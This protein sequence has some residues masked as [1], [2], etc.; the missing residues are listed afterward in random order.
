MHPGASTLSMEPLIGR[1]QDVRNV[2]TLLEEPT[3]QL[4][5]LTGPGGVGKTR[6]AIQVAS[7]MT[8][9]APLFADG[10]C[11][12]SLATVREEEQVP[13]AIM[14]AL[15]AKEEGQQRPLDVVKG[16]LHTK[17]LLLVLDNFEQVRAAAPLMSEL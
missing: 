15:G 1:E 13:L 2:C 17:H 9:K 10:C 8:A 6:L 12:V 7:E 4:L 3:I 14:Q 11:Y 5:T 16:V